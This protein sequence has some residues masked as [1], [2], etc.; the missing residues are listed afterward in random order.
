MIA[1]PAIATSR[2][3]RSVAM[4]T[5][6]RSTRRSRV[7]PARPPQEAAM[8][9]AQLAATQDAASTAGDLIDSLRRTRRYRLACRIA[10]PLDR[11]RGR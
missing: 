4:A 7:H 10:A 5:D 9:R 1:T 8:L 3:A 6:H 2:R 11:L